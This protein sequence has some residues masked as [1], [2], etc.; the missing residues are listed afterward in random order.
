MIAA[1]SVETI[2]ILSGPMVGLSYFVGAIPWRRAAS[3]FGLVNDDD[4]VE[5]Q[6]RPDRR[7][8][9]LFVI[10]EAVV[11]LILAV[12]A[13]NLIGAIAPGADGGFNPSSTFGALS[14]QVIPVWQSVALWTG[15]AAVLGQIAP[16]WNRLRGGTG[17]PAVMALTLAFAP[18][19]FAATVFGFLA[20]FLMGR[21]R[22]PAVIIGFFC[23]LTVAWLG[24]VTGLNPA[25]G[26][27]L[28]PELAL[29]TAVMMAMLSPRILI[30]LDYFDATDPTRD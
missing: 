7:G 5:T 11:P 16:I 12:A 20:A 21:N 3:R 19:I 8:D 24:W 28:G 6:D 23:G 4:L 14:N 29:W 17:I 26:V 22:Q 2:A 13:W 18:W 15:A 9:E 30:G 1:V 25:W 10:I 27:N